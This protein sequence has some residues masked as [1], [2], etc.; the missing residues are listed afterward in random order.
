MNKSFKK[1]I[2]AL[3]LEYLLNSIKRVGDAIY[4]KANNRKNA[5]IPDKFLDFDVAKIINNYVSHVKFSKKIIYVAMNIIY[6]E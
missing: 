1:R 3:F 6:P 5:V 4:L 2:N